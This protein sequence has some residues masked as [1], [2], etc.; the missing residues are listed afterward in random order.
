MSEA[1]PLDFHSPYG[2]SKRAADQYVRDYQRIYGLRTVVF[3]QSAVYGT[4]QFGIEDQGRLAWFMIAAALGKPIPVARRDWR[5]DDQRVCV[6][7]ISK[8][9]LELDWR[10]QVP[11]KVGV[12]KLYRGVKENVI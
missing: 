4:R 11:L 12:E 3:R 9:S 1:Q 8:A 2:C 6:Y 5:P 10:S 7:N